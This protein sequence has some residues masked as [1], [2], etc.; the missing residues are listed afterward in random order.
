MAFSYDSLDGRSIMK[1]AVTGAT[2]YIG[3]QLIPS[4]LNSKHELLL[5]G[6]SINKLHLQYPTQAV[7]DYSM[8]GSSLA[9][10]DVVIH[11]A[12]KN[13]DSQGSKEEFRAAN[14]D[15]LSDLAKNAAQNSV[16]VF[17]NVTTLHSETKGSSSEYGR[18]KAE[19]RKI[20]DSIGNLQIVNL[21]LPAVYSP[22]GYRGSLA[23]LNKLPPF[24][25]GFCFLVLSAFKPTLNIST[26]NRKIVT[27]SEAIVWPVENLYVSDEQKH[28]AI[29]S[30]LKRITD[31]LFACAVATIL[32]PILIAAWIAIR[33]DSPGPAIFKQER[34]GIF[35]EVFQ[36][37]KF[38]T[39]AIGT[40]Q[41]G[42]H[43]VGISAITRVGKFLRRAKIDELP[44]ILNI[45]KNEM[46]LVGPRPSLPSQ[47]T[48]IDARHSLRVLDVRPG[49]TGL[50]QINGIDMS[51][52]ELLAQYDARYIACRSL[53]LDMKI[54]IATFVGRGMGDAVVADRST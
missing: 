23:A 16:K 36:C 54:L 32:S 49:I 39:M 13:N 41:A 14:V 44:Q 21:I 47:L 7:A 27:L 28:N 31:L 26:L 12:V 18:T 2:G 4:L 52:P 25:R 5:F 15:L 20:L 6:R 19:G 50:A 30:G 11:L 35:G 38:R 33:M 1:I 48:L 40:K 42:S 10:I 51:T 17:I 22:K 29:Y 53:L 45:F 3:T 34:V 9:G 46:S 8:L 37:Y 24:L 43:E